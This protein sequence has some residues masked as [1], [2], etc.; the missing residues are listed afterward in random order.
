MLSDPGVSRVSYAYS[1]QDSSPAR[2]SD[3]LVIK[4]SCPGVSSCYWCLQLYC[5]VLG[6]L[7]ILLSSGWVIFHLYV[8]SHTHNQD[9]RIHRYQQ[10]H[11]MERMIRRKDEC[12]VNEI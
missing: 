11:R 9:L 12:Q 4:L 10:L 2:D 1:Y 6:C 8:L 5:M 7:G 3:S